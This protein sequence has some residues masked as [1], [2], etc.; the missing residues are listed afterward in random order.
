MHHT[1]L[2]PDIPPVAASQKEVMDYLRRRPS[3][4][5]FVHGKAGAGKS[6]IIRELEKRVK[7]CQVLTPTNLAATLYS[8]AR[9]LHSFFR[10]G[11]DN[12]KNGIQDPRNLDI[13]KFYQMSRALSGV[14]MLVIDEISMVRSDTLEM[15]H[16]LC[17]GAKENELPFGGIPIVLV[18]DLFQLPP[19]VEN[20]AVQEYLVNEYGG[21]YFY[22]SHVIKENIGHIR[23]FELTKS[24]RQNSDPEFARILDAFRSP[25]SLE[26]RSRLLDAINTR[27]TDTLP[28]DAVYIAS[29]NESINRINLGRL[30]RLPG[31]IRSVEACYNVRLADGTGYVDLR[32]SDLTSPHDTVPIVL[33]SQYDALLNF[34][35]GARVMITK[36]SKMGGYQNGLLGTILHLRKVGKENPVVDLKTLN[37]KD[38]DFRTHF[39]EILLDDSGQTVY[40]P[41]PNDTYLKSQIS[42]ERYEMRYD[43]TTH[44]IIRRNRLQTTYQFPIKPAYAFTIHKS[45]G[46]TYTKVIIDLHSH[47]FAPGQLYVAL[48][49][50]KSLAG[51]FLTKQITY[52]DIITDDSIFLFLNKVRIANEAITD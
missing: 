37:E 40:C 43:A 45:Q 25:L 52:S 12:F 42:D 10:P 23:L 16:R 32:H 50:A 8:G 20:E 24:Y 6:Y 38:I 31:E 41:N 44:K 9:T 30:N 1:D 5:T 18:G 49:R 48:S 15:I 4:I 11:F 13:N 33:P 26:K 7:G 46:Q 14:R 19:V 29:S 39:F 2:I 22:D 21:I 17:A 36:N 28:E 35:E 3:G 47:I 34:K 51:L 27:V